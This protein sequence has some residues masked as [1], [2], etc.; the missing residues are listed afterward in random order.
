MTEKKTYEPP[1]I[2]DLQVD[3]TQAVGASRCVTGAQ[4]TTTC[5]S[6]NV[7]STSCNTGNSAVPLN[8]NSGNTAQN[9]NYGKNP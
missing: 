9:C 4:A 7:A 5:T 3:Y 6:G 1:R 8:C 2:V